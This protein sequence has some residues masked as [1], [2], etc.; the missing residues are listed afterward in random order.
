MAKRQGFVRLRHAKPRCV[1]YGETMKASFWH[2]INRPWWFAACVVFYVGF[3]GPRLIS[4][5]DTFAVIGGLALLVLL[6]VWGY[7]LFIHM[8]RHKDWK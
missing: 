7:Q 2:W 1:V 4:S 8:L 3:V 5:Q 6:V